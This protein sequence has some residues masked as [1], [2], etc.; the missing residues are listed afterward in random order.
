MK[1]TTNLGAYIATELMLMR[2]HA[3]AREVAVYCKETNGPR[4]PVKGHHPW[5]EIPT[6]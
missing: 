4:R 3:V 5:L 2:H 6:S 1:L